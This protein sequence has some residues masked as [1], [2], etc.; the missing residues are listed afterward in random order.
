MTYQVRSS[1]GFSLR[2]D[3]INLRHY[4]TFET[5]RDFIGLITTTVQQRGR[6][7]A[8]YALK[9]PAEPLFPQETFFKVS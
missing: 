3:D 1:Q 5:A 4:H 9:V 2:I 7:R 6:Y 8:S